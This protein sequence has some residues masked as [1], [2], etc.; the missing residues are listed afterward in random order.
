MNPDLCDILANGGVVSCYLSDQDGIPI[1]PFDLSSLLCEEVRKIN[2]RETIQVVLPSG[3]EVS[4]QR[5]HIRISGYI[6]VEVTF[7]TETCTSEPIPFCKYEQVVLCAPDGTEIE[8][9]VTDFRCSACIQCE[10]DIYQSVEINLNLCQSIQAVANTVI[11]ISSN[12]CLPRENFI[13]QT[14][15]PNVLPPQ[16]DS[17][18]EEEAEVIDF[19]SPS[20]RECP[21]NIVQLDSH[22][23]KVD[24]VY[25]WI[26]Q[27]S[28][29]EIRKNAMKAPIICDVCSLDL[30]VPAVLFCERT[31]TGS[32]SC[33]VP[34]SGAL[35]EFDSSSDA[36]SFSPNPSVT[37]SNGN[38]STIATVQEGTPE[39]T[40]TITATV[41]IEEKV[42]TT[43]LG[44]IVECPAAE[45]T[46]LF[47]GPESITC[48]GF[49]DGEVFC[50][51]T[52]I[53][54]AEISF[55]SNPEYTYV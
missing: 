43:T 8:C 32:L 1:D 28:T 23:V 18:Q 42:Y 5:V 33:G 10:N 13:S 14:C 39:T 47:F 2:G 44:T 4:L 36:V 37:D 15:S 7:G 26:I 9:R 49:I 54:G 38:F 34:I 40:V 46:L 51:D 52:L 31:L 41:T 20:K 12:S 35:I 24:K 45:C 29:I 25:D 53:E 6:V 11:N 27:R 3:E 50:G 55:S 30:F 22:C 17:G 21:T 48:D 19:N 16:C